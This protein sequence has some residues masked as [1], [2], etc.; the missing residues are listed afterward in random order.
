MDGV[1]VDNTKNKIKFAKK[2]GFDLKPEE[3]PADFIETVLPKDALNEL[4][5]LLYDKPA[6]ALQAD[7]VEGAEAGL[8]K[9][10]ESRI[11]YFLISRRK[12]PALA[13]QLLQKRGLWPSFF[14]EKNAFFVNEP[15]EKDLKAIELGVNIYVDDQPGVLGKLLSVEKRF[16]FDRF[17]KFG[18]L[19]FKHVKIS[20]WKEFLSYLV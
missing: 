20:S 5:R 8:A 15:E 12:D 19:P 6:T 10:K 9:L 11:P 16:L 13:K 18:D 17:G 4:R 7:L 2:L 14:N 3:T 1:I